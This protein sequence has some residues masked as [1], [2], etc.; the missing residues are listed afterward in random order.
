MST[1][2]KIFKSAGIG[3]SSVLTWFARRAAGAANVLE[4]NLSGQV[5]EDVQLSG[6][7]QRIMPAQFVSMRELLA[8]VSFAAEDPGI[9]ALVLRTADHDLGWGRAEEISEAIRRFRAA[10]KYALAFLEEPENVDTLLAAAC[11]RVAA[12]PGIPV[13]LTGLLSEVMY[14]KGVLDKLEIQ[15]ELFQAGK[16]KSAVEPYTRAGMSKEHRESVESL[17]DSIFDLWSRSLAEGRGITP[18]RARELIDGGPWLSEEAMEQGLLDELF[19][20]DEIDDYLEKWLGIQ[21]ARISLDKYLKLYG[22]RAAMADPWK[23]DAALALIT[24]AGHI[25]GGE[26]RFY[27]LGDT[28]VGADTLRRALQRGGGKRT[29]S[30]PRC[31]GWT[32]P[33]A[34]PSTPT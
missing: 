10:G 31:S 4:I 34:R 33:A 18:E 30:P 29:P 21:P 12:P 8:G 17:L 2:R 22:P 27:G 25:H 11:D 15:P 26:S 7:W 5:V 19:Y 16:Y 6:I 1:T 20:E 32:A 23:K 3:A 14:F 28:T 9:K 24:A 13:Y